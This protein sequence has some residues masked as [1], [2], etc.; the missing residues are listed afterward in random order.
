MQLATVEPHQ[1]RGLRAHGADGRNMFFAVILHELDVLFH[2]AEHLPAPLVA[3]G[4]E[5]GHGGNGGKQRGIVQLVGGQPRVETVAQA[6]IGHNGIAAHDACNIESLR[7][8]TESD[9][10]LGCLF[11]YR[12]KRNVAVAPEG[13]V[14]MNLVADDDDVV[15]VAEA[16]QPLQGLA[17]PDN[18]CRIVWVGENEHAALL[19]AHQLQV[20][21]VHLVGE[22]GP[23]HAFQGIHHY[24]TAVAFG[25]KPE[26]M[27]DGRLDDD[28]L[29]GFQEHI[30]SHAN[31]FHDAGDVGEPLFLHIPLVAVVNPLPDGCPQLRGHNR[32]AKQ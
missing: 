6:G 32:V 31:A 9:A 17:R 24:L 22:L 13:H 4:C 7:W 18:A 14:A 25:C 1:E 20:V 26:G 28:L 8:G 19:V 15:L 23:V 12:R 16:G 3:L 2:I 27:I 30:N 11:R 21:E 29:V 5:G 10:A